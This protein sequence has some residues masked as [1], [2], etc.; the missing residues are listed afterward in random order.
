MRVCRL[1]EPRHNPNPATRSSS[2]DNLIC[3]LHVYFYHAL[4]VACVHISLTASGCILPG[5]HSRSETYCSCSLFCSCQTPLM[6]I[7]SAQISAAKPGIRATHDR[8]GARART[9]AGRQQ[10]HMLACSLAQIPQRCA[11]SLTIGWVLSEL[12]VCSSSPACMGGRA[13][14]A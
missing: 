13:R 4:L 7:A 12:I 11:S 14:A 3:S 10:C 8:E 9:A 2:S 6:Y 5:R 1:I